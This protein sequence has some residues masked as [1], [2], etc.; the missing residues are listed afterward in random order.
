MDGDRGALGTRAAAACHLLV[1]G[2][3]QGVGFRWWSVDRA[4]ELRVTGWIRNLPDGRVEV[5]IE[6]ERQGVDAMVRA[7]AEGPRS[8][9]VGEVR[10]AERDPE[11][12]ETFEVRPA[13]RESGRARGSDGRPA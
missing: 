10:L 2:R 8:A 3:V 9:R 1:H 4:R 6:G 12:H 11:G 7:L 13:P 5:W